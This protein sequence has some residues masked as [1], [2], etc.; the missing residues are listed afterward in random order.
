MQQHYSCYPWCGCNQSCIGQTC[1]SEGNRK[2]SG[3]V[4]LLQYLKNSQRMSTV[5]E[6]KLRK[7]KH[8]TSWGRSHLDHFMHVHYV[9]AMWT[10]WLPCVC[11]I[12]DL[13]YRKVHSQRQRIDPTIQGSRTLHCRALVTAMS[14]ERFISQIQCANRTSAGCFV[15]MF[16]LESLSI[17]S[18]GLL[19]SCFNLFHGSCSCCRKIEYIESSNG[20]CRIW[21]MKED[22]LKWP[23]HLSTKMS[24]FVVPLDSKPKRATTTF[25]V[26][27]G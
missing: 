10:A 16:P 9:D 1:F 19:M 21:K 23:F 22:R 3:T 12:W 14:W 27:V 4:A 8:K 24:V 18:L 25:C 13:Q 7:S 17:Q 26:C 11:A 6:S 5:K 2:R 20:K 15:V